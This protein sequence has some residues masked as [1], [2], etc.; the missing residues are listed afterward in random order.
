MFAMNTI[1]HIR[2]SLA[3]LRAVKCFIT[4][5]TAVMVFSVKSCWRPRITIR[6]PT[7]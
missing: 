6:K 4:G 3:R 2:A 5:S 7:G 1:D